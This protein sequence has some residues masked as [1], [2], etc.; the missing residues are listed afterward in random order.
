MQNTVLPAAI[1]R[2]QNLW[3][4]NRVEGLL[5]AHRDCLSFWTLSPKTCAEL[6][7]TPT[8]AG[9]DDDEVI[10]FGA[11]TLASDVY[12][13]QDQRKVTLPAGA[14]G[15]DADFGLYV[16]AKY[17]SVCSASAGTIAYALTCQRDQFDRPTWGRINFCPNELVATADQTTFTVAVAVHE[18]MH[19]LGFS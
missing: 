4:L 17:T 2:H 9:V 12:Y 19:A 7:S 14:N 5:Q 11:D 15:L 6:D 13:T 1:G 10:A 3:S 18:I 16:T 8:C